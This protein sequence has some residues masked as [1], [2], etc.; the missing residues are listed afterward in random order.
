MSAPVTAFI[1]LGSNVGD[2][3]SAMRRAALLVSQ[4]NGAEIELGSDVASLF[5]TEPIGGPSGQP[6]FLNSAIR[7]RAIRE[8][9]SLLRALLGIECSLGRRRESRW[10]NRIIDLDLLLYG[11]LVLDAPELSLPHPRLHERRFVLEP[12]AEIGAIVIH[13]TIG[14]TIGELAH[15][16]RKSADQKIERVMGPEWAASYSA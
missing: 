1:G 16:L 13:P 2:R 11:D 14:R 3:L 5:E 10:E 6:R 7:M 15:D 12:L 9:A 4:I 8:P